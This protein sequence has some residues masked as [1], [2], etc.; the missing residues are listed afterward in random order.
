MYTKEIIRTYIYVFF[1]FF[2]FF[3]FFLF[4]KKEEEEEGRR[5]L[6]LSKYLTFE[7][8]K[9][10]SARKKERE[11]EIPLEYRYLQYLNTLGKQS[12]DQALSQAP[13]QA[14]DFKTASTLSRR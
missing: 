7:G 13:Y 10:E 12:I 3:V 5:K 11:R 1:F 14:Q 9:R 4:S 8:R 2:F 6:R